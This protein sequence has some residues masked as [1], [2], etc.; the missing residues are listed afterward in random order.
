MFDKFSSISLL[1]KFKHWTSLNHFIFQ[2]S[3]KPWQRVFKGFY[4][5]C[6][7]FIP[8]RMSIHLFSQV[9][10]FFSQ[11]IPDKEILPHGFWMTRFLFSVV[12]ES[13]YRCFSFTRFINLSPKE[14]LDYM[15]G[16]LLVRLDLWC[17]L[18]HKT[19]R[20]RKVG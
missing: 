5:E 14:I 12:D 15:F 19:M 3:M 16:G 11:W 6:F 7:I 8:Q 10:R 20:K 1:N 18:L 13:S 17:T 2:A 9:T 4:M